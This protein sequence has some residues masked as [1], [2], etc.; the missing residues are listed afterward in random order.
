MS[1]RSSKT[2]ALKKSGPT[3]RVWSGSISCGHQGRRAGAT[4]AYNGDDM[5]GH[6][7]TGEG[8]VNT[9]PKTATLWLATAS[10]SEASK[11]T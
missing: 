9:S 7:I 6:D 11:Q 2:Y 10:P 1:Y 4:F 8:E 5:V 3:L